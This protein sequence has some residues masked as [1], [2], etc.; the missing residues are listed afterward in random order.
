MLSEMG[1]AAIRYA[2]MG[3]AVI[4][5]VPHGKN[6]IFREWQKVATNDRTM[7]SRWFEQN[8]TCNVGIATGTKSNCFVLDVDVNKGGRDSYDSLILKHGR[9]PDTWQQ[10]TGSG[11]F[12]LFFRWPAFTV[13]NANDLFPGIDIR[14][15]GGQ[16]VAPPS[17]HA[18]G[19]RYEWDG[20]EELEDSPL[21]EA[22]MWL[23][24]LLQGKSERTSPRS[25][26]PV[27]VDMLPKGSRHQALVSM[28]GTMRRLGL[29][30]SEILAALREVNRNRCE[31]PKE[32]AQLRQI[33]E[34]MMR[35]QCSDRDLFKT[36]NALWRVTKARE[37]EQENAK[38]AEA[39][40]LEKAALKTVDGLTVYRTP[41]SEQRCVVDGLL[42]H[43][44]TIFAGSPKSGKSWFALQLALAVANGERFIGSRDVL[45]PGRVVYVALEENA[46]RTASRMR[47]LQPKESVYLQNISMVY[48][49]L[50][51]MGGG[52]EQLDE[53]AR[54]L[55]P[56]LMIVDTFTACVGREGGGSRNVF[57]SEYAEMNV[58]HKLAEKHDFALLLIHHKRKTVPGSSGLDSVAGSAGMTA[59]ADAIWT[60]DKE[61]EG[62]SSISTTG[63]DIEEQTLAV[64]FERDQPFGWNLIGT[65]DAVKSMKDEKEIYTVLREE[66]A[67]AVGKVAM[68]LRMNVNR[69]RELLYEMHRQ[70]YVNRDSSNRYYLAPASEREGWVQ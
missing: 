26:G 19:N 65:G 9:F 15:E 21:A 29:N 44:L 13:H 6:P 11:G 5:L 17:I 53:L 35:Y 34:S 55:R 36:A 47:L 57:R 39:A 63:R 28:A 33:A 31:E 64:K 32:D 60:I 68:L 54:T 40:E 49:L 3:L 51:L 37:I 70:G 58:L 8:P 23:L 56:T 41:V 50:P 66:G 12:H 22:P 27:V 2:E 1:Q 67:L 16:V 14:G 62:V 18:C 42:F 7:V 48:E 52:A 25:V 24:E 20:A 10:I 4:P 43:G 38:Q 59:A 61:D 69:T 45:R 46:T 30:A